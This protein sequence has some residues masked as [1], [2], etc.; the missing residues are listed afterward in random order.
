MKSN[1]IKWLFVILFL[2]VQPVLAS[3]Q[4]VEVKPNAVVVDFS[5]AERMLDWLVFVKQEHSAT[6][7]KIKFVRLIGSTAGCKAI[8]DH[9]ARF[10]S[11]WNLDAFYLFVVENLGFVETQKDLVD[12]KGNPTPFS[13]RRKLWKEAFENPDRIRRLIEQLKTINWNDRLEENVKINLPP[14]I[15]LNAGFHFVLF[16]ASSGFS[17]N[18]DIALDVLQLP[19]NSENELELDDIFRVASH[20]LHHFGFSLSSDRTLVNINNLERSE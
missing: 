3:K 7:R 16:G 5:M 13:V 18:N 19:V 1:K 20:E 6:N 15:Q 8:I 12:S 10:D 9:W 11:N 14:E 17:V 2:N 4:L